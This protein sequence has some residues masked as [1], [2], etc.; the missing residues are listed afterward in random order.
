M[1]KRGGEKVVDKESTK[2]VRFTHEW[3]DGGRRHTTRAI[4]GRN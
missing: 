4:V 2:R 1:Q 3:P